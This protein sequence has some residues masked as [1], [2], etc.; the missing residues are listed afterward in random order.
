MTISGRSRFSRACCPEQREK[1]HSTKTASRCRCG[2]FQSRELA[3]TNQLLCTTAVKCSRPEKDQHYAPPLA[4][5]RDRYRPRRQD[6]PLLHTPDVRGPLNP[7]VSGPYS[8]PRSSSSKGVALS[9]FLRD[10]GAFPRPPVAVDLPLVD[11]LWRV[12]ECPNRQKSIGLCARVV[13]LH[14]WCR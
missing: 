4:Q 3:S 2:A 7:P 10:A 6:Y 14:Q 12:S 8:L 9:R 5:R 11:K 13:P 1:F